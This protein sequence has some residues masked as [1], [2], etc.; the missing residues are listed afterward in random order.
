MNQ[1]SMPRSNGFG[2][3]RTLNRGGGWM[4]NL[5]DPVG[6]EFI[7]FASRSTSWSLDV[8][9]AYGSDTFLEALK[10]GARIIA[11]DIEPRHLEILINERVPSELRHNVK[12]LPGSFLSVQVP[13]ASIGSILASRVFHFMDGET[14]ERVAHK[15][16]TVLI[17]GGKL[18][19]TADSPYQLSMAPFI[20]VYEARR[21]AGSRWPGQIRE[22]W[23]YAPAEV[24]AGE[25]PP[26]MNFLDPEVLTR[27]FQS[28]GFKIEKA[29][30]MARP[31]GYPDE[32]RYDG[33]EA[34]ALIAV[35]EHQSS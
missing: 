35:K 20:S 7:D 3:I 1:L 9:S 34:V 18:F 31:Q 22:M 29:A 21:Q 25:I 17:P 11:N 26:L 28:A 4:S 13:E 6:Q 12:T 23:Y 10:K 14:I 2:F 33:R 24:E 16:F 30:F 32:L 27:T 8:G 19:L 15:M 5:K